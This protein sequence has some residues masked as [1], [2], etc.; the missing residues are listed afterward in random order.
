S[1]GEVHRVAGP[2][3]LRT[4]CTRLYPRRDG[5]FPALGDGRLPGRPGARRL[6]ARADRPDDGDAPRGRVPTGQLAG[7]WV[8]DRPPLAALQPDHGA[9]RIRAAVACRPGRT[10]A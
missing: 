9:P 2:V 6:H 5:R 1:V 4:G 8:W 7:L 10:P 3:R